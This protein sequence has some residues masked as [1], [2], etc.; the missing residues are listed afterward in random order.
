MQT[1]RKRSIK[2][3]EN[4]DDDEEFEGL[5]E[6]NDL[7]RDEAIDHLK[8]PISFNNKSTKQIN[9]VASQR[10]NDLYQ[11]AFIREDKLKRARA[12]VKDEECT[13]Q[14]KLY[15]SHRTNGHK[16]YRSVDRAQIS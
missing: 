9:V 14:P 3:E 16:S 13:F 15:T 1:E 2:E 7:E 8:K 11:N 12:A 4:V 5:A 6:S 10:F